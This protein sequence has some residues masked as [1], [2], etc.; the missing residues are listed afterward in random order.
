MCNNHIY[1]MKRNASN[2]GK[3]LP[4]E[5]SLNSLHCAPVIEAHS[6]DTALTGFDELTCK[7]IA[8]FTLQPK[9][10]LTARGWRPKSL[11][12][13]E[14]DCVRAIRGRSSATTT[15]VLTRDKSN[16]RAWK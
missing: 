1:V 9:E 2:A 6:S 10:V 13:F 16:P 14:N 12:S 7:Q 3:H 4:K 11:K 15:Q 5:N 8:R